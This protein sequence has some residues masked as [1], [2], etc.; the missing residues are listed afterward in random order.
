MLVGI[1]TVNNEQHQAFK[2]DTKVLQNDA[3]SGYWNSIFQVIW[4]FML[5]FGEKQ[6]KS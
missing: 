2:K 1:M 4:G 5:G 3:I 6:T